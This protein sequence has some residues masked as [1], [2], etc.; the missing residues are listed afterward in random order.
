MWITGANYSC[1]RLALPCPLGPSGPRLRRKRALAFLPS[2]PGI[3]DFQ[4]TRVRLRCTVKGGHATCLPQGN[5]LSA[6][7]T[8]LEHLANSAKPSPKNASTFLHINSSLTRRAT[9][10]SVSLWTIRTEPSPFSTAN[11][12]TT[13]RPKLRRSNLPIAPGSWGVPLLG[14]SEEHTSELQSPVHLV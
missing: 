10:R 4:R 11:A 5:S 1:N 2:K 14:R 8:G 7:R 9:V 12:V 6:W 3:F 13:K